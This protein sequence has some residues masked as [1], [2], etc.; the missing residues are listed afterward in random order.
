VKNKDMRPYPLPVSQLV[1]G[2]GG[3]VD[4]LRELLPDVI[5][6]ELGVDIVSLGLVYGSSS[7]RSRGASPTTVFLAE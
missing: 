1:R 5:N 2:G 6:P 4:E 7:A 3:W